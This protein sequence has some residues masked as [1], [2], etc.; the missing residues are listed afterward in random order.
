MVNPYM[1]LCMY[2]RCAAAEMLVGALFPLLLLFALRLRE[3]ARATVLLAIV[4]AACWLSDLPA[5]VVITYALVLLLA[6]FAFLHRSWR[7]LARG[8][9]AILLGFGLAAFFLIPAWYEQRWIQI[10]QAVVSCYRPELWR[11]SFAW[12]PDGHWYGALVA[13]I[14]YGQIA[15]AGL[16]AVLSLLRWHKSHVWQLATILACIASLM[17]FPAVSGYAWT[18]LP[19]LEYVQFPWRWLL[20]LSTCLALLLDSDM[21]APAG[22]LPSDC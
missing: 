22:L 17:A 11:Y 20:V 19:E 3:S 9:G 1:L 2:Q 8:A 13:A 16:S 14:A 7:T 12:S 18:H 21:F 10:Q 6:I 5:A 15:I 4:F